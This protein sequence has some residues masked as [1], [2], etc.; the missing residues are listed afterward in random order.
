MAV[1]AGSLNFK[2]GGKFEYG[3]LFEFGG[4]AVFLNFKYGRHG[5]MFEF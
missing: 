4:Y 5:V 2:D 3:G 1:H